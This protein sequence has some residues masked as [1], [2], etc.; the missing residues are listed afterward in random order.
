M[1]TQARGRTVGLAGRCLVL[2]I[3][4]LALVHPTLPGRGRTTDLIVVLDDSASVGEPAASRAWEEALGAARTLPDG[5]RLA[6]L[7][8]AGEAAIEQRLAPV[9][10]VTA[11]GSVPRRSRALDP[12]STDLARALAGALTMVEAA[13]RAAVL[14][15]TDGLSTDDPSAAAPIL[16]AAR[17][18]GIPVY[19]RRTTPA[20]GVADAWIDA[21]AA[22]RRVRRGAAFPLAVTLGTTGGGEATV[23]ISMDGRPVERRI[24][25]L[26]PGAG[27]TVTASLRADGSGAVLVEATVTLAGDGRRE[28]DRRA[29][30]VAVDEPAP[31]LLV[32]REAAESPLA[33]SLTDGGRMVRTLD[34]ERLSGTDL[35]GG[36]L[37]VVLDDVAIAD[38]GESAWADLT[39]AVTDHGQGLIVLGGPRSFG[40]GGYRRSRLEA[41]LPVTAEAPDP[42]ERFAL[43]FVVDKSGSMDEDQGGTSRFAEALRA[44]EEANKALADS[45][46]VGLVVFDA[47]ARTVIPLGPPSRAPA[48]VAG[49][50]SIRAG[51]GT[52]LAPALDRAL[53]ELATVEAE[54]KLVVL[55]SDGVLAPT[56][57]LGDIGLR[58]ARH[59]VD[60]IAVV[61]GA[62]PISPALEALASR[63]GSAL[64]AAG[65][66]TLLP[67]IVSGTLENR[68]QP[69]V[70]GPVV[71]V[72]LRP[73][74]FL[75]APVG[76][77]SVAGFAVSRPRPTADVFLETSRGEPLLA[78]GTAGLG[79]VVVLT[80]GLSGWART[81]PPWPEWPRFIAGLVDWTSPRS[82]DGHLHVRIEDGP[83][84][85]TV[86]LDAAMTATAGGTR[87]AVDGGATVVVRDPEAQITRITLDQVAPGRY[88]GPV[89]VHHAGRHDA[90]IRL[91]DRQV[92][93]PFLH[94]PD[95]E[96]IGSP[97]GA[98]E[99]RDQIAAGLVV[100]WDPGDPAPARRQ[101]ERRSLRPF[102]LGAA[103]ILVLGLVVRE[104]WSP[105]RP[106]F[107]AAARRLSST[108]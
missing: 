102:L 43:V 66:V 55:I 10:E 58:L 47:L 4:V 18:A 33:R 94:Q 37:L 101:A 76:W 42:E 49:I 51:G 69:W 63:P 52:R 53:S 44:V 25:D 12:S 17:D 40:S 19:L 104:R 23:S 98:A 85:A 71:P 6:L 13:D 100:P 68:R 67:R 31:I 24:L 79:R 7:R 87:W 92:L 5:S 59:G 1:A 57:D 86:R 21:I 36:P 83:G 72:P 45:D 107:L 65:E 75:A 22:P 54:R 32:G 16:D 56:E 8:F 28:N 108:T 15:I 9:A 39:Q 14:L 82:A 38:T 34:P 99:W 35:K 2:A 73:V 105:R 3:L 46:R 62:Q 29:V 27:R 96:F 88:Q 41:I 60:L 89:T 103:V 91:G 61:I 74:P 97:A 70:E 93:V 90:V 20:A 77:P 78:A 11:S 48:A 95:R 26:E 30:L 106:G 80:G 81:R 84:R 64:L 50:G